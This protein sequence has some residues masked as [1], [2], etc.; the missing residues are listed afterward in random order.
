[1]WL[2]VH[3]SMAPCLPMMGETVAYRGGRAGLLLS[4]AA[5]PLVA[6]VGIDLWPAPALPSRVSGSRM[7]C[8]ATSPAR[9]GGADGRYV[10][11]V[12]PE[13]GQLAGQNGPGVPFPPITPHS[14]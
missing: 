3:C 1:L 14:P 10:I 5:A 8:A 6:E 2:V 12:A 9:K 11:E 4:I 13:A 7:G